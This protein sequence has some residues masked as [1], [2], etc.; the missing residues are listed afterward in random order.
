MSAVSS[1]AA[2]R[3]WERCLLRACG[4]LEAP[5]QEGLLL[6]PLQ[7]AGEWSCGCTSR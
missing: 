7:A 1:A 4:E 2:S 3:P 6:P 5:R